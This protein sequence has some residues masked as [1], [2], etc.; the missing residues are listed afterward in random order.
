V[1]PLRSWLAS[2]VLSV[3]LSGL[4]RR[5]LSEVGQQLRGCS[6]GSAPQLVGQ[7]KFGLL[8]W[9]WFASDAGALTRHKARRSSCRVKRITG[10]LLCINGV[11]TDGHVTRRDALCFHFLHLALQFVENWSAEDFFEKLLRICE[12]DLALWQRL[13][14]QRINWQRFGALAVSVY[15]HQGALV[16]VAGDMVRRIFITSQTAA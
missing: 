8:R 4:L 14:W 11:T 6:R 9:G 13:D 1:E 3:V 7:S 15:E 2:A 5:V 12:G 10:R 16:V